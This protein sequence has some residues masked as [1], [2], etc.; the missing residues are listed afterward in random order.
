[1]VPLVSF[2]PYT[3]YGDGSTHDGIVKLI[4]MQ[5]AIAP[6]PDEIG[7]LPTGHTV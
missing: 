3:P 2:F 7:G 6:A 5:V 1:M 4:V